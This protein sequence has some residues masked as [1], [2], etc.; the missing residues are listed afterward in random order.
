M[1]A[2]IRLFLLLLLTGGPALAEEPLL[3]PDQ[4]FGISSRT[5]DS[6]I[7]VRWE[8]ADG[9]YLYRSKFRFDTNDPRVT[10]GIPDLPPGEIKKDP[11]FGE[12]EIYRN[13][14]EVTIPVHYNGNE[15]PELIELNVRSQGCADIGICFPPHTQTLLVAL[16]QEA[17]QPPPVAREAVAEAEQALEQFT[18]S[19]TGADSDPAETQDP[20]ADPSPLEEL[21]AVLGD[22]LG[23]EEDG[24]LPPDKAY[25]VVP[26][27]VNGNRLRLDF[28]VAEGTYLYED[29]LQVSIEGEGVKVGRLE[30]PKPKIK[31]DTIRPDGTIG[32]VPV[33]VH[34][35]QVGVPLVREKGE[36][37]ETKLTVKYQ[38]CAEA[39]ICYPPQKKIF[40]LALPATSVV[41]GGTTVAAPA[42]TVRAAPSAGERAPEIEQSEQDRIAGMLRSG[43]TWLVVF[44]FFGLGLL[45]SFTPCVFPMIPILSGII[46]GQGNQVTTRRA[47]SL[48]V[49]FVLAMAITYTI[50]G[51][52]AGL[53]GANLQAAFQ[54]PWIL[55]FFALVFVLLALSMFGFYDLQLPAS[56][57]S[58]L[59]EISNRQ[60]GGQTTGVAVMGLLSALI[61]GPCVAPPLAGALIFIGQ[62]GD[63]QLGGLALF[64]MSLGMGAPLIIIGTSAGKL[65][66]KAGGWMDAVKAVFGVVMLGLAITM[67]ERFLP[68][69]VIMALWGVLLVVSSVYMGALRQLPADAS[70]WSR[71]WKGLGV[72]V[73]VY[74]ILFL[75]GVA[76]NGRDTLQPLR[77]ILPAG[78]SGG[79]VAV[80]DHVAFKRVKSVEDLEREVAAAKAA[81]KPVMLD[82]YADWCIYCKTLEK[83][84]FPDP[85]VRAYLDNFVLL[86]ADVTEQDEQDLALQRRFEVPAPPALIFWNSRGEELR[87][88]RVMGDIGAGELADHLAKVR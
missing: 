57:Q 55:S 79:P 69:V 7:V 61:V 35:F 32:D 56:W 66:P 51:V 36:A 22:A 21:G 59:S 6:N 42:K 48:S 73:L 14:V 20:A 11:F 24:F 46:A 58:K 5:E 85:R 74:G 52:L 27:V 86:Q 38:G 9:Y 54:D 8:I 65:L 71:L 81:G 78:V 47:F 39:G 67:L 70:G 4:A 10:L 76:A 60:Q 1:T 23:L 63:W 19:P 40:D 13:S 43:S 34:D 88:L 41:G 33:F 83:N 31:P 3:K 49:V 75:V 2:L 26:E 18:G 82:F 84:V 77:G 45:L 50:A 72:V 15:R 25:Q 44:S 64:A 68:E 29:K 80:A 87:P 16:Q 37:L 53:F 12:I 28:K 17:D 62:T 30:L